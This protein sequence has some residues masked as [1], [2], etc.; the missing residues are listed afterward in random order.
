MVSV[1]SPLRSTHLTTNHSRSGAD[2]N[3]T[4]NNLRAG[5]LIILP[6]GLIGVN[7]DYRHRVVLIDPRRKR[8]V[9]QYGHTGRP[10]RRRGYLRIP[11]GFDLLGPGGTFPTH[12]FT[13]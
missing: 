13:G 10:G 1:Q 11:D 9:W 12:P 5:V 7:D 4:A 8:I 3:P 2:H 6:H